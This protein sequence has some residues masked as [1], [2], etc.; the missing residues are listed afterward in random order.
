MEIIED[1]KLGSA[2]RDL[3]LL[4][5]AMVVIVT[6]IRGLLKSA[7][8]DTYITYLGIL[9]AP[10]MVLSLILSIR[11]VYR[12]RTS[13][14][15]LRVIIGMAIT[16]IILRLFSILV[17]EDGVGQ[18]VLGIISSLF[19]LSV[20]VTIMYRLSI[21]LFIEENS[22]IDKLWA[23]VCVYFLIGFSFG[24]LYSTYMLVHPD[25]L[26][27]ELT[28]PIEIYIY[29]IIYSLNILSGLDPIYTNVSE[30]IQMGAIL[31]STFLT[32]FLVLL[33]GRL[34]GTNLTTAKN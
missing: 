11:V 14:L 6:I 16:G 33:I 21:N 18:E 2:Y 5:I 20:I 7:F 15:G 3:A 34:L 13:R 10:G 1:K 23:S 27:F 25:A 24:T 29:G 19:M 9:F 12:L 8:P 26:G 32:L 17:M 30:E 31:E 28:Q 22:I 4:Y